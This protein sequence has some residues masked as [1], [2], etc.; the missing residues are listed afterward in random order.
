[1]HSPPD[2]SAGCPSIEGEGLVAKMLRIHPEKCTGC[3][4]CEL[5]CAVAHGGVRRPGASRVHAF[6][7]K[8]E[9][10]TPRFS[11]P[12]MCRQCAEAACVKI[13]PTGAMHQSATVPGLVEFDQE[14]CMGCKACVQVCPFGNV[15]YD[16]VGK[17][18][19]KCD[20]CAGAPKCAALCPNG[21]LE[22]VDD[23]DR[24]PEQQRAFA[25]KFRDSLREAH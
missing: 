8:G 1:M 10:G 23:E 17:T 19:A 22:F 21:A 14:R 4:R 12:V 13:C 9:E 25:E 3:K 16:S 2:E 24:T 20:T 18:I 5:A 7:W 6:T 15:H 11:V